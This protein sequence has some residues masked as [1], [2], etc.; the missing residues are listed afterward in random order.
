MA[1]I[2]K[3]EDAKRQIQREKI[4]KKRE[5]AIQAY[6]TAESSKP[7]I[8]AI[9]REYGV[10][11]KTLRRHLKDNA[12]SIDEFNT[13]KLKIAKAQEDVIVQWCD[14]LATRHLPFDRQLL[15]EYATAVLHT[16]QPEEKLSNKW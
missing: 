9:A 7:S 13:S 5:L 14:Q 6:K 1:R 2:P 3:S 12:R 4:I 8:A 16:T 10:D 15:H 11:P